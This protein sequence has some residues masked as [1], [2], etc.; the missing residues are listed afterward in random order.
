MGISKSEL[1]SMLEEDELKRATLLVFA[2]KQDL[3]VGQDVVA[4]L[5]LL[6]G[7]FVFNKMLVSHRTILARLNRLFFR[8]HC[9][10]RMFQK[11]WVCR[12]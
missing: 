1:V 2:N 6:V 8:E 7:V 10:P 5:C 3:P 12:H 11:L 4:C 9:L